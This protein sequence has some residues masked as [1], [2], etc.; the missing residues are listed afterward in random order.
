MVVVVVV[1][2]R[3]GVGW[4]KRDEGLGLRWECGCG[5]MEVERWGRE[6][7]KRIECW[8]KRSRAWNEKRGWDN[9][10]DCKE[11]IVRVGR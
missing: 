2:E 7:G 11:A 4:R 9:T 1:V 8:M 10:F 5:E 3:C 6:S